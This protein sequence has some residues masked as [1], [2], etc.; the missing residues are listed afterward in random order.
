MDPHRLAQHI[1]RAGKRAEPR[2][3]RKKRW[4]RE[5]TPPR[6]AEPD[7]PEP[8][9]APPDSDLIDAAQSVLSETPANDVPRTARGIPE[10]KKRCHTM[11]FSVSPEEAELLRRYAA[12]KGM[13]FSEWARGSLF[14]TMGR[15][16]PSRGKA[17]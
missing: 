8:M 5:R 10:R 2:R 1:I 4:Q 14:R 9:F 12:S 6:S 13:S 7:P 15:R 11:T 17:T 3:K 16:V